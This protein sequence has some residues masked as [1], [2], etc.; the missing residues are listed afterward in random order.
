MKPVSYTHL[1]WE[2]EGTEICFCKNFDTFMSKA[3]IDYLPEE[4][5]L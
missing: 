4:G 3:I 2:A 5:D 1:E